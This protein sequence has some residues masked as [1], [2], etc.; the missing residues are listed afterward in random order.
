MTVI[1]RI[2]AVIAALQA[3]N[4]PAQRGYSGRV[5]A[6][7]YAPKTA[8]RLYRCTEGEETVAVDIF[9][10]TAQGAA[11][12]E[13]LAAQ[14]QTVLRRM[15]AE[16]TVG[17][18]EFQKDSGLFALQVQGKW[19]IGPKCVVKIDDQ[20]MENILECRAAQENTALSYVDS[21]SGE[22]ITT[23]TKREWTITIVDIWPAGKKMDVDTTE[24]FALSI[25]REGGTESYAN[26][27]WST[28]LLEETKAGVM[29]TRVARTYHQRVISEV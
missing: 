16:V 8:V 23:V 17:A 18:C 9:G 7:V 15:M 2:E 20:S 12:C 4:I 10:P 22:I 1:D 19:R 26:C 27:R 5:I 14:V 11:A 3:Q 21:Q 29:R 28:I 25:H 24:P 13:A 6:A